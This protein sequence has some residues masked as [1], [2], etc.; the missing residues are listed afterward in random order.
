MSLEKNKFI[1]K[2]RPTVKEYMYMANGFNAKHYEERNW[3]CS[4]R[5]LDLEWDYLELGP[6]FFQLQWGIVQDTDHFGI[7]YL[8]FKT[9]RITPT[10]A[11]IV[12]L[13]FWVVCICVFV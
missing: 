2:V 8:I 4:Y 10:L 5:I 6:I 11:P 13:V 9:E 7:L 3:G 1:Y 12:L